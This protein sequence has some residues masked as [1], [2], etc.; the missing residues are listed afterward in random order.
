MRIRGAGFA[1]HGPLVVY[2]CQRA[3]KSVVIESDRLIRLLTPRADAVD[4]CDV[5]LHFSDGEEVVLRGA[6]RYREPDGDVPDDIFDQISR[7]AE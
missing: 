4:S 7:G 3:A 2:V 1:S 5:T 6:F